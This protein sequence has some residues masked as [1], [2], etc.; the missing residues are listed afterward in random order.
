MSFKHYSIEC[1]LFVIVL[2]RYCFN[3]GL[4]SNTDVK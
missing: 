2:Q 4:P 3:I 1:N